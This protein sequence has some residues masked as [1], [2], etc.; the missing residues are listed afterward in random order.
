MIFL[1]FKQK[2]NKK[3]NRKEKAM[4]FDEIRKAKQISQAEMAKRLHISLK[5]YIRMEENPGKVSI[6]YGMEIADILNTPF[7]EISFI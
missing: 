1:E 4:R 3:L 5:R 2:P 7:D 6:Y